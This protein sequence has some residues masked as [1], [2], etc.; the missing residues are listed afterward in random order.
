[1]TENE[2][3]CYTFNHNCNI[4]IQMQ[5]IEHFNN[6]YKDIEQAVISIKNLMV[7]LEDYSKFKTKINQ[8]KNT[9]FSI[10]NVIEFIKNQSPNVLEYLKNFR[11]YN[12]ETYNTI[13]DDIHKFYSFVDK[14]DT[15]IQSIN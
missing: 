6:N 13:F 12:L 7:N 15:K 2:I 10:K 11:R 8:C 5:K 4:S 1:M 3:D 14:L 9:Y